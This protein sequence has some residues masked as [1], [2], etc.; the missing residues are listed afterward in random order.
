MFLCVLRNQ[1]QI[2]LYN[3][4]LKIHLRDLTLLDMAFKAPFKAYSGAN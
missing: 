4:G 2:Q 3:I 1:L